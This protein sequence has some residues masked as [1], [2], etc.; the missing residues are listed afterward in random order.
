MFTNKMTKS[1]I[2]YYIFLCH[3]V[4]GIS[5]LY[6]DPQ[7]PLE[8]VIAEKIAF[9]CENPGHPIDF[10]DIINIYDPNV[11]ISRGFQLM[12]EPNETMSN[13]GFDLL[14]NIN[15]RF[16]Y[17]D[18]RKTLASIAIDRMTHEDKSVAASLAKALQNSRKA[19]FSKEAKEML[20]RHL[21]QLLSGNNYD[22][23]VRQVVLLIG[24]ADI[25][26][27]M[28][29]LQTIIDQAEEPL[30][31]FGLAKRGH[32]MA[33]AALKAKARM[34]DQNAIQQCLTIVDEVPDDFVVSSPNHPELS[35]TIKDYKINVLL[36][37]LAYIRQPATVD[38]II[39]YLYSNKKTHYGGPDVGRRTYASIAAEYL[40]DI[41][42]GFP[43]YGQAIDVYERK[44]FSS[45]LEFRKKWPSFDEFYEGVK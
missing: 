30:Q 14:V 7:K 37:D 15:G 12:N 44:A 11:L 41:I 5:F 13:L 39:Q 19:D 45:D 28:D 25:Q 31:P 21:T 18:L 3:L 35:T 32:K 22:Y 34:G 33:F 43:T 6:A 2:Y 26:E 4:S 10:R 29:R 9:R 8:E 27:E 23:Y 38:Y 36:K 40:E 17:P 20:S 42:V 1:R 24:V 16:N